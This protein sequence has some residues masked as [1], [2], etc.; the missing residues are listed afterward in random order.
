VRAILD[1][2][3]LVAQ[4]DAPEPIEVTL[5]PEDMEKALE[6]YTKNVTFYGPAGTPPDPS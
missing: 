3:H 1:A 6:L 4:V 5:T 2:R